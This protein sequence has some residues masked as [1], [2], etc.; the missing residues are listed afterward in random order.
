MK[1]KLSKGFLHGC[2]KAT[3]LMGVTKIWPEIYNDKKKD[4]DALKEDWK[5]VGKA[6]R[7]ETERFSKSYS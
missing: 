2:E 5:H 4:Y 7:E 1:I 3:D 6:I